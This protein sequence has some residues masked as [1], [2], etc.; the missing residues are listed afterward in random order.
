MAKGLKYG[1]YHHDDV[2]QISRDPPV[3][4][5]FELSPRRVAIVVAVPFD[6]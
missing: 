6:R 4:S 1:L 5:R 3:S 2:V